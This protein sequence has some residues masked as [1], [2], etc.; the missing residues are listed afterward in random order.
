MG[1]VCACDRSRVS[2]LQCSLGTPRGQRRC[3]MA[4][5]AF[6]CAAR[7]FAERQDRGES[8][9]RAAAMAAAALAAAAAAAAAAGV[10]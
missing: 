3:A 1:S 5:D 2:A 4:G 8:N 10:Q 7:A 6:L 9:G